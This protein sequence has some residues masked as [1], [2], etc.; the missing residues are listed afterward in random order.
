MGCA[1][2]CLRRQRRPFPAESEETVH[3]HICPRPSHICPR[4]SHICPR[5]SH[6]CPR[7]S[8]IYPR[9]SHICPRPSHICPR[10]SHICPR[11]SHICPRPAT[12]APGR[13][14]TL[15]W[16][17]QPAYIV[18]RM[19]A[20]RSLDATRAAAYSMRH[21]TCR[22]QRG[23]TVYIEGRGTAR[24]SMDCNRT[25]QVCGAHQRRLRLP[26]RRLP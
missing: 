2:H 24:R 25:R 21:A 6:I 20:R 18:A 9:P 13:G 3:S 26:S 10:P 5:P 15:H 7:P 23:T 4:P 14:D 11:P 8:H 16:L 17:A 19:C 22:M 1:D 12:S